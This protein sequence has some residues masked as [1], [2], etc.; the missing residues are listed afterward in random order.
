MDY[1]KQKLEER[2]DNKELQKRFDYIEN[3]PIK[4]TETRLI[5]KF[6]DTE[7]KSCFELYGDNYEE[8]ELQVDDS[9]DELMTYK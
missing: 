5:E 9:L 6:N 2:R 4:T 8:V 3:I 1:I 7:T